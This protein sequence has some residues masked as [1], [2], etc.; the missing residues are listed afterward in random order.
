[1]YTFIP[2]SVL[3][4]QDDL[5]FTLLVMPTGRQRMRW[6]WRPVHCEACCEGASG[7]CALALPKC[8]VVRLGQ[9]LKGDDVEQLGGLL[10][11]DVLRVDVRPVVEE[12]DV[13]AAA[14]ACL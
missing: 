14:A 6:G 5:I 10:R 13:L 7:L 12:D 11:V 8:C 4:A 3:R 2:L 1:M 9:L